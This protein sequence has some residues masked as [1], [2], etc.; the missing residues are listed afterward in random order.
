MLALAIRDFFHT[1]P[2]EDHI[3]FEVLL[4]LPPHLSDEIQEVLEE[5]NRLNEG[6]PFKMLF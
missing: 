3:F 4:N 1:F 6:R 2:Y 5:F